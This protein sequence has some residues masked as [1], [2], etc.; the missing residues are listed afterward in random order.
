MYSMRQI[1][2]IFSTVFVTKSVTADYAVFE[3]KNRSEAH[4]FVTRTGRK[5]RPVKFEWNWVFTDRRSQADFTIRWVRNKSEAD[6]I[7]FWSPTPT[8]AGWKRNHK[9]Q[10]KLRTR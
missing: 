2:L 8:E 7:I 1:L 5:L 4:L 10:Q 9:L 3:T 6:V